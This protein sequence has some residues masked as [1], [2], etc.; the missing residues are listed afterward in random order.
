MSRV[1]QKESE[2]VE[3]R[4]WGENEKENET[5]ERR[6]QE[7]EADKEAFGCADTVDSQLA[8]LAVPDGIFYPVLFRLVPVLCCF[9]LITNYR[10][11][12]KFIKLFTWG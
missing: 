4:L 2:A 8:R 3:L 7:K 10:F 11:Q 6:R 9:N 5:E 12:M 1:G